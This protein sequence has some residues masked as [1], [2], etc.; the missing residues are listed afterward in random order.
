MSFLEPD[1]VDMIQQAFFRDVFSFVQRRPAPHLGTL[2]EVLQSCD[3]CNWRCEIFP[4][5]VH[6]WQD[7]SRC[8][9]VS[10]L[11]GLTQCNSCQVLSKSIFLQ[12]VLFTV[13]DMPFWK[14]SRPRKLILP[15]KC[16]GSRFITRRE[17]MCTRNDQRSD[18]GGAQVTHTA[19]NLA[20]SLSLLQY[21]VRQVP[22]EWCNLYWGKMWFSAALEQNTQS[23]LYQ[24]ISRSFV[25][26]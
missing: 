26:L 12:L 5:S 23:V 14:A 11:G 8:T 6:R 3:D 15:A 21:V 20:S 19:M 7:V 22:C 17:V 16:I 13:C 4:D 9:L 18:L 1:S 25:R 24:W 10:V 2:Q